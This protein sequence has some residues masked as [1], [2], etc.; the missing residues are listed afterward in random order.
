MPNRLLVSI[1]LAALV[2]PFVSSAQQ[3]E[4]SSNLSSWYTDR[5][6]IDIEIVGTEGVGSEAHLVSP[7]RVLRLRLERAYLINLFRTNQPPSSVALIGFDL[8]TGL[9]SALFQAS[10]EQVEARGDP[11]HQ[12]T[13]ADW[14]SRTVSI[15]LTSSNLTSGFDLASSELK[16]CKGRRLQDDLFLLEK[17]QGSSCLKWSLGKGTK[18]V[19]Q[20]SDKV[21]LLLRCSRASLGCETYVP[22]DGFLPSISFN[23]SHLTRWREVTEKVTAFLQSKQHP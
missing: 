16:N 20:Y 9:P 2:V 15:S 23:E 19:A 5:K 13:A 8:P 4:P 1:C 10:P 11:I 3:F 21:L 6:P 17:G 14:A 18:Y 7:P 22:F 12:L